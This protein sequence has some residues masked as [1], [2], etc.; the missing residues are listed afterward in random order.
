MVEKFFINGKMVLKISQPFFRILKNFYWGLNNTRIFRVLVVIGCVPFI[1]FGFLSKK[2][3]LLKNK[4]FLLQNIIKK[5]FVFDRILKRNYQMRTDFLYRSGN[6]R[7]LRMK[8]GLPVRG[9]RTHTN[10]STASRLNKLLVNAALTVNKP[11][12][13]PFKK[14]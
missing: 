14:R 12:K 2:H 5:F 3:N 1:S 4:L 13:K 8:S 11:I 9:Q 7:G 6:Y 10:A